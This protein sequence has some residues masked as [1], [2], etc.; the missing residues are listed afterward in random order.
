MPPTDVDWSWSFP[1]AVGPSQPVQPVPLFGQ[2]C[3]TKTPN[4]DNS[5]TTVQ[6]N[7]DVHH[8]QD[9]LGVDCLNNHFEMDDLEA[10]ALGDLPENPHFQSPSAMDRSQLGSSPYEEASSQDDLPYVTKHPICAIGPTTQLLT[11]FNQEDDFL[12]DILVKKGDLEE[13]RQKEALVNSRQT[14][15]ESAVS[16][17]KAGRRG[18]S[19]N[20]FDKFLCMYCKDTKPQ[21]PEPYIIEARS[22]VVEGKNSIL[23]QDG[24]VV[25]TGTDPNKSN[26]NKNAVSVQELGIIM[27]KFIN[28]LAKSCFVTGSA[29]TDHDHIAVGSACNY[30]SDIKMWILETNSHM[31]ESEFTIFDASRWRQ[32][33]KDMFKV[34]AQRHRKL[35]TPL[36]NGHKPITDSDRKSMALACI[37]M[38]TPDAA[39]FFHL[40]NSTFHMAGRGSECAMSK[41][42]DISTITS[43]DNLTETTLL[44]VRLQRHKDGPEQQVAIYPHKTNFYECYIFSLAYLSLFSHATNSQYIFPNYSAKALLEDKEGRNKSKVASLW[45]THFKKLLAFMEKVQRKLSPIYSSHSGKKASSQKMAEIPSVSGLAQIFRTGWEVRGFHSLFD[46]VVGT[47]TMAQQAGK[48]LAGWTT[49]HGNHVPGGISP[50]LFDIQTEQQKA[51]EFSALL[52]GSV[53]GLE[54]DA[55]SMMTATI[56][57]FYGDFCS[58]LKE[59]PD[60]LNQQEHWLVQTMKSHLERA[61]VSDATFQKWQDEINAGFRRKNIAALPLSCLSQEELEHVQVDLRSFTQGFNHLQQLC[62]DTQGKTAPPFLL[63]CVS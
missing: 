32:L 40:N 15:S 35:G 45:T 44:S 62:Q 23:R 49:A 51:K 58:A 26:Y 9:N 1:S 53:E 41:H 43:I 28:H 55:K 42:S 13:Q 11:H 48:A 31:R 52:F 38:G 63:P 59:H 7:K 57:R 8:G 20:Q 36:V 4:L 25:C 30:L 60:H 14:I 2:P 33:R 54:P 21:L 61:Q 27:Q 37:W 34:M 56:L 3:S 47:M 16:S 17:S 12:S 6:A 19:I 5:A 46:Y 50:S 29:Q 10:E 18:T 39:E 22:M 24:T